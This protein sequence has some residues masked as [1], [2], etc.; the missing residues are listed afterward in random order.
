MTD[1]LQDDADII[2]EEIAIYDAENTRVEIGV[3]CVSVQAL[4][5]LKTL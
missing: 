4:T 2:E 5:T 3:M 1:I